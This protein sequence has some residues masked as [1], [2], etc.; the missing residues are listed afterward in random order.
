MY[1]TSRFFLSTVL[2]FGFVTLFAVAFPIA[3]LAAFLNNILEV[4]C[5]SFKYM[6]HMRRPV[7]DI[8]EGNIGIWYNILFFLSRLAVITNVST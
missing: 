8:D 4:R 7:A 6:V 1:Y 2:Q 3:P 5:D